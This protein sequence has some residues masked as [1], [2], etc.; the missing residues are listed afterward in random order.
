MAQSA[1]ER[2]IAVAGAF[3]HLKVAPSYA[4]PFVIQPGFRIS[5][6]HLGDYD[7]LDSFVA[8]PSRYV[9]EMLRRTRQT[10]GDVMRILVFNPLLRLSL[11]LIRYTLALVAQ[12]GATDAVV[13]S[14]N[15]LPLAYLLSLDAAD[16]YRHLVLLSCSDPELDRRLLAVLYGTAL[17]SVEVP[18]PC[19]TAIG[20]GFLPGPYLRPMEW[21][22]QNAIEVLQVAQAAAPG[23][24][25][26]EIRKAIRLSAFFTHHAGDALFMG[27]AA[28]QTAQPLFDD[29]LIHESY[30]PIV[31][32]TLGKIRFSPVTGPVPFRGDYRK[33]D[34]DHFMDMAPGLPKGVFH[35]YCRT[36][37]NYNFT[38]FHY[39][40][41]FRFCLGEPLAD[42]QQLHRGHASEDHD[43]DTTRRPG[44]ARILLHFDAGWPL[45][46]YPPALQAELAKLLQEN[47]YHVTVLDAKESLPGVRSRRFDTLEAFD[48]LL[49]DIDVLVG[50][51][52]FP[53][54]YAAQARRL[55]TIHLFSST[56]PVHSWAG[57]TSS[58]RTLHK[59]ATC[60]PCLGWDNC[61]RHGGPDCRN[62][63]AP[64][65]VVDELGELL[66]AAPQEPS[67]PFPI[68]PPATK[69]PRQYQRS[70][71]KAIHLHDT[72]LATARLKLER[73]F[74]Y[75]AIIPGAVGLLVAEFIN[76]L[77]NE[78]LRKAV[79]LTKAFLY[80]H[81][82]RVLVSGRG[83]RSS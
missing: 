20:N 64:G 34:C 25:H 39:I 55:K 18:F 57:H 79:Y 65:M 54:H 74:R 4:G 58:H 71:G 59:G 38:N 49:D 3:S 24:D 50:M 66:A 15:H 69:C 23:T 29:L 33:E 14:S 45:K 56:H 61:I 51:D 63:A 32:H 82:S 43:A 77:R 1:A 8:T 70:R 7:L 60:C 83:E 72:H 78:G 36:T 26:R 17:T 21:C 12:S 68:A 46:I 22:A 41:H 30:Y 81:V 10:Q 31:S 67:T 13:K 16:D 37:R 73:P 40:D 35:A 5:Q 9:V 53:V 11:Y 52:S 47:G 62:F 19:Q 27:I 2:V 80:R 75:A 6:D 48:K 44:P 28:K 42:E 76:A